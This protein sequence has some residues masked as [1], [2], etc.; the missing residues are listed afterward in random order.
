MPQGFR[1]L[2][3]RPRGWAF[4]LAAAACAAGIALGNWQSRR[5]ADRQAIAALHEAAARA[6]AVDLAP[7]PA[8]P[9]AFVHRRVA[10]R[11]EF[12]AAH[13]VY[14]DNRLYRGRPGY[15]VIQPLRLAGG[16]GIC[17]LV[18]RGW[19]AAG[20]QRDRPPPVATPAGEQWVQGIGIAHLAR[21]F[22]SSSEA[23]AGPVRQNLRLEDFAAVSG[24]RLQPFVIEQQSPLDDGLVRDWPRPEAGWQKNKA[25]AM[26]WY[27]LAALAVILFLALST[28]REQ[29]PAG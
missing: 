28:R 2:T 21:A 6:P 7:Q 20:P 18:S 16:D 29:P 19:I 3:F 11:G 24:L 22:D 17:V 25:Y 15:H 9:S 13:T 4:A 8:D 1:G 27:A 10:A 23:P 26:Q 5:A 14:L 12:L